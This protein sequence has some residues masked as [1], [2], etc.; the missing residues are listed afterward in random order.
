MGPG[1]NQAKL[2]QLPSGQLQLP[3][4]GTRSE[5]Q[6]YGEPGY[7]PC[8]SVYLL[9]LHGWVCHPGT[10]CATHVQCHVHISWHVSYRQAALGW[11][12][13][14]PAKSSAIQCGCAVQ[15][16]KMLQVLGLHNVSLS[17]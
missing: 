9:L 11:A 14:D 4:M 10:Q 6:A 16:T 15:L 5:A 13:N 12:I 1:N 3:S 7:S 17:A 2:P 8:M